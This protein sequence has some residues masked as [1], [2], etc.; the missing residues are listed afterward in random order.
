MQFMSPKESLAGLSTDAI[1]SLLRATAEIVLILDHHGVVIDLASDANDLSE[2][3]TA[4]AWIGQS[5]VHLIAA[6]HH[7]KIPRLFSNF[8]HNVPAIWRQ[9]DI[10]NDN[11]THL[12]FSFCAIPSG[13]KGR[14]IVFARDMRAQAK[15]KQQLIDAQQ[16]IERDYLHLRH[17]ESRFRLLFDLSAEGLFI[18]DANNLRIIEANS[19]AATIMGMGVKK[20]SGRHWLACIDSQSHSAM[21]SLLHAVSHGSP[22]GEIYIS[23]NNGEKQLCLSASQIHELDAE[24]F[25]FRITTH[26]TTSSTG[27][28]S[29]QVALV[30]KMLELAPDAFVVTNLAGEILATNRA[31]MTMAQLHRPE[32]A[33][34]ESLDRWIDKAGVDLH[35]LLSNLQQRGSVR[36]FETTF[37]NED[38][39]SIPVEISAV[40]LPDG[41]QNG[42]GFTIRDVGRRL[43]TQITRQNVMPYSA[44]QFTEL[45]GRIPLR[46]IVGA[47]TNLIEKHCITTALQLT[48]DNRAAAAEMLGLSRQSLYV[49][50]RLYELDQSN[51][52]I[53]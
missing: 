3:K 50:L 40:A 27:H 38:G 24:L 42:V 47:T 37:H 49:K 17:T 31:F 32:Q 14:T 18:V 45:V 23:V 19:S 16:S 43:D 7:S 4:H 9:L 5:F 21:N 13:Y 53:S 11:G 33:V 51:E 8:R 6:N 12:P 15:T 39:A 30:L 1:A 52:D 28:S 48:E 35:V 26:H 41:E 44:D 2:H 10:H 34:G 29:A 25:L 46:E 22:G 20:L 36:L